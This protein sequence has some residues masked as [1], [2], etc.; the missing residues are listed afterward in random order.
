M[1]NW[2]EPRTESEKH[3]GRTATYSA[4]LCMKDINRCTCA[5]CNSVLTLVYEYH[6]LRVGWVVAEV[7][8]VC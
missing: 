3:T 7:A 4:L 6:H 8:T 2:M 1:R 5:K